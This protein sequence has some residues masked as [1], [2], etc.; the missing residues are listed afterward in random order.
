MDKRRDRQRDPSSVYSDALLANYRKL[1][2]GRV[3]ISTAAWPEERSA[4]Q[5]KQT[6]PLK[7]GDGPLFTFPEQEDLRIPDPSW[8]STFGLA[9]MIAALLGLAVFGWSL[10]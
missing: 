10:I 1:S 6:E 9:L 2:D 4:E 8:L 3:L 7:P 5:V